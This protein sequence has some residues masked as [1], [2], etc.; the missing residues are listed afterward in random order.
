MHFTRA[1][2]RHNLEATVSIQGHLTSPHASLR[3]LGIYFDPKLNWGAH[4]KKVEQK[5]H[6][7]VQSISRLAQ[8]TWGA[9]FKKSKLLYSTLVRPALTYGSH[10][11]AEARPGGKIPE[12]IVKSLRSVQRKCLKLVTGA[13]KSTSSKVLEH[14]TSVLPIEL[15]LKQRRVQHAG[16]SDKLPVRKTITSA[17][18]RIKLP[19]RGREEIHDMNRSDDV[20]EWIRI[21]GRDEEQSRQ[22]VA[23]KI[24]AFQEWKHSW[25][26]QENSGN[27]TQANPKTWKAANISMDQKTNRFRMNYR[28]TPVQIHQNLSRA[29]SSITIQMRSAYIGL[30]SYLYR[31]KVPGVNNPK[32]QCGYPSQDVRHMVMTCPQWAKGRGEILLKSKVRSYQAMIQSP[33]DVARITQWILDEG[34][35]EQFRLVSQVEAAMQEMRHKVG[36]GK[37]RIH[38]GCTA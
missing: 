32:C 15:Y 9:T 36:K 26:C 38:T 18:N 23:V 34:Y 8:S 17:C 7:Q 30:N 11:L 24:A 14:E 35:L 33:E 37:D 22:K 13:Y 5:S 21:C 10:I 12:R 16:L 27:P 2:K 4:I 20:T 28:G 6:I 3:V 31:R 29:K 1:R 25:T 19:V